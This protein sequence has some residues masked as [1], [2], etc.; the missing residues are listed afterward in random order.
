M[1]VTV[2]MSAKRQPSQ[3]PSDA[4]QRLQEMAGHDIKRN[5]RKSSS[6]DPPRP[7]RL[8]LNN[9]VAGKYAISPPSSPSKHQS[10]PIPSTPDN[11][12]HKRTSLTRKDSRSSQLNSAKNSLMNMQ[13]NNISRQKQEGFP[14]E[15]GYIRIQWTPAH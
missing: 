5:Y 3:L 15:T 1:P 6:G 14:S 10:P 4:K 7:N 11:P 13:N 12:N 2:D 8:N 9:G